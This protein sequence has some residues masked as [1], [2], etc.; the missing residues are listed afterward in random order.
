M[1]R[2][3]RKLIEIPESVTVE[4]TDHR[5]KAKGPKGE[6]FLDVNP[7]AK[8]V[9]E[10]NKI[11]VSRRGNDRISRGI[12]GLTRQLVYNIIVGVKDGFEKKL[13]I[14]GV[15]YRVQLTGADLNLSLGYSHPVEFKAPSGITFEVQKNFIIVKGIDKQLVGQTAAKIRELRPPEPYKGKGIRYV[16]ELVKKK[17]GKAAKVGSGATAGA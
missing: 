14:K 9:I 1:S 3:G 17:A 12:H 13:E 16:D 5:L 7:R 15:G 4:L 2:I 6:L 10:N 8:V 11:T